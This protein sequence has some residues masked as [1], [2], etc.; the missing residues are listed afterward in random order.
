MKAIDKIIDILP[1]PILAAI[2]AV[3]IAAWVIKQI[4]DHPSY[5]PVLQDPHLQSFALIIIFVECLSD[6]IN[7]LKIK[8]KNVK[9]GVV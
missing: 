1:M 3:A 2:A 4:K 6:Q 7:L 9:R 5:G 8:E